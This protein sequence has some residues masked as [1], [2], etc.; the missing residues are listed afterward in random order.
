MTA[1]RQ[2]RA[3]PLLIQMLRTNPDVQVREAQPQPDYSLYHVDLGR[4]LYLADT[5]H[6]LYVKVARPL[7]SRT[8]AAELVHFLRSYSPRDQLVILEI[9]SLSSGIQFE[10]LIAPYPNWALART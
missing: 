6:V 3:A 7:K 9:S 4:T 2:A 1:P 10:G 8:A 5:D